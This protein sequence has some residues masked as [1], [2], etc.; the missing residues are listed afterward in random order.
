MANLQLEPVSRPDG[1]IEGIDLPEARRSRRLCCMLLR[2]AV[3][4]N[5]S[6]ADEFLP[7]VAVPAKDQG[8]GLQFA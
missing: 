7:G 5:R 3:V 4:L 6:G 8:V 1:R 2:L